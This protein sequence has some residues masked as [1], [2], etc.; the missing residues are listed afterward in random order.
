M[1]QLGNYNSQLTGQGMFDVG[2]LKDGETV[3][4]SGAAGSVGLVSLFVSL[5][6]LIDKVATQ[7]ALAHPKC[8]VIAIAG[9]D[10]KCQKLRDLGCHQVL[11]YKADSFKSDFRKIGLLDVFFDN[12]GLT[13]VMTLGLMGQSVDRRLT[14]L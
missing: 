14:W 9:T 13:R 11:N 7:I 6:T 3:L 5:L 10:A 4:I 1:S 12:G 2:R 8:K